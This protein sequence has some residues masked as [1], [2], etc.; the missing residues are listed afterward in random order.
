MYGLTAICVSKYSYI[1]IYYNAIDYYIHVYVCM[2][3]CMLLRIN[4]PTL[5]IRG[6]PKTFAN[7]F[8]GIHVNALADT[9]RRVSNFQ[10]F[11]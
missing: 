11:Y 9:I 4:R 6:S 7:K 5:Y 10:N 2:Y 1:Q 8:F 3:I